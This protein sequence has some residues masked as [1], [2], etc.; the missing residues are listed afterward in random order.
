[1][2]DRA[3][4]K[5]I[6]YEGDPGVYLYTH[7]SGD[8]LPMM[9]K[10]A[11]AKK[12]R[13][14]DGAYLAR[15]VFCEMVVGSEQGETGFGISTIPEGTQERTITLNCVTQHVESPFFSGTFSEYVETDLSPVRW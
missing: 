10:S 13:W 2:G 6:A 12:W 11:L 3:N 4:V 5:V 8:D 15:I 1:M 14:D 7:C 9:I